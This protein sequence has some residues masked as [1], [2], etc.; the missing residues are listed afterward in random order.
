MSGGMYLAA[1]G[2]LVQQLRLEVLSN[3]VANINTIGYKGD[4]SIFQ[5]PEETE[6]LLFETPIEGIETWSPYAPPFSTI[7]DFSQGAIRQTG[8]RLDVAINGS[9]LFSVQTPDGV[10][11]TRQGSFTLDA[12]GVLVTQDGYPVLGE[13]GEINLEEGTVEIDGEGGVY[14]DGDEVGRLQIADFPNGEA[15]KKVG[16]GRFVASE[17]AV[18][19]ERPENTTLSQGYLET[20]NVNPVQAMTEMIETSRAFEAYQKVIQSS[21]E[22]TSKSINEVGRTI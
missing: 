16:N 11:Y 19:G 12:E 10:Q 6:P 22:A 7:I 2:A 4:K 21:D 15:L 9:G 18:R 8:N 3:N 17:T 20:S 13:G 14:V 5:I 1:A